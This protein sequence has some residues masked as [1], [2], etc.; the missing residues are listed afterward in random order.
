MG[1]LKKKTYNRGKFKEYLC[2]YFASRSEFSFH[3]QTQVLYQKNPK[4][5]GLSDFEIKCI[6]LSTTYFNSQK[7]FRQYAVD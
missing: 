1:V 4:L 5:V 2:H 7:N 3:D 6:S